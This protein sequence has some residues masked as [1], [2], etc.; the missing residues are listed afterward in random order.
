MAL[1]IRYWARQFN[2]DDIEDI[3]ARLAPALAERG[4]EVALI[5]PQ[6]DRPTDAIVSEGLSIHR[7]DASHRGAPAEVLPPPACDAPD[8][9]LFETGGPLSPLALATVERDRRPLVASIHCPLADTTH[10]ADDP[11]GA[12]LQRA[13][14]IAVDTEAISGQL[15]AFV[16][17]SGER[18]VVIEAGLPLTELAPGPRL[19]KRPALLGVGPLR[20]ESGFD[21]V[22]EALADIRTRIG[23]AVLTLVGDGP[24]RAA[25]EAQAAELGLAD[26]V[27]FRGTVSASRLPGIVNQSSLIVV[28]SRVP[29]SSSAISILGGQLLRPV[30]ASAIGGLDEIIEQHGS[31]LLVVPEDPAAL[32]GAARRLLSEPGS[33]ADLGRR[34]RTLA[35]ERFG[36]DRFVNDV[37]QLLNSA[38]APAPVGSNRDLVG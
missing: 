27:E 23:T 4:H 24:E 31:G 9:D 10:H 6:T 21:I 34:G 36:W 38:L 28:P 37:E 30:I 25:L 19:L 33:A 29:V 26:V 12:L 11:D 16:P 14:A 13:V 8:L 17:E 2:L 32:A 7:V 1:R 15:R 20:R 5:A 22:I 3:S 35:R 18:T